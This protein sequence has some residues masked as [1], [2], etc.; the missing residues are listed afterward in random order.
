MYKGGKVDN[1]AG[2]WLS[3]VN[4][5]KF[6]LMMPGRP[7][8]NAS[9]YQELVPNVAMDRATIVSTT[10]VVKTSAGEFTNCLK[11]KETT[12]LESLTEYKYYAPGIGMV[13]DGKMSLVKA[14][15]VDH[16]ARP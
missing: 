14:G 9:Y 10:E 15:K 13:M 12:P 7:L 6:G 3:G 1:H 5:G 2:S 16:K 11:I 4:G 8:I